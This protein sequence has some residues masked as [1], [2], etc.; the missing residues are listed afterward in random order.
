MNYLAIAN[1]TAGR[2]RC[3]RLIPEIRR[4]LE[5]TGHAIEFV[6]SRSQ[7]HLRELAHMAVQQRYDGVISCGGDGTAHYILQEL[8]G[9]DLTLGLVSVGTGNDWASSLGLP[10]DYRKA[11]ALIKQGKTRRI[12]VARA[13][14]H[15]Y[16]SVAGTGFD[17]EV[18]R[19]ANQ[20][21][22]WL[23]GRAVY[24]NALF[25]ALSQFV[26]QP[27]EVIYDGHRFVGPVMLVAVGNGASYG[28]GVRIVPQ[29]VMDDGWLDLC[30]VKQ[31][32]RL[33]LLKNLP[34]IYHG[35]HV[36]HPAVE[37]HRARRITIHSTR[38]MDLFGDGEYLQQ[39]PVTIEVVPR[40][41][42]IIAP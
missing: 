8:L 2:G 15:A 39:I 5:A 11:C 35:G 1:P 37:I 33:E 36:A 26:P 9:S 28:G 27:V 42:R 14:P 29:A 19:L 24:L 4:C 34:R 6:I 10:T 38:A 32:T 18:N 20:N 13:G 17:A 21:S 40:V 12:D 25:R 7:Q 41:L 31:T 23:R 3:G 22:A 16:V 30:I